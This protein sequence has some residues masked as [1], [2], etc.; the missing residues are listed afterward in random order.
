MNVDVK[1]KAWG[2]WSVCRGEC[3]AWRL[4]RPILTR[5]STDEREMNPVNASAAS[6][7]LTL[8]ARLTFYVQNLGKEN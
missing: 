7:R 6:D 3:E 8:A 1:T 5:T 4:H 2:V